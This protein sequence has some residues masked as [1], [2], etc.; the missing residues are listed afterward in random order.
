MRRTA[1]FALALV[2]LAA[3]STSAPPPAVPNT[4]L[5]VAG[6]TAQVE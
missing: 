4:S 5:L 6:T 2:F 1:L 3:W